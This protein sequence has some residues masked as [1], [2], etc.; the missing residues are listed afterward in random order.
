MMKN[1]ITIKAIPT[2]QR[3]NESLRFPDI[4]VFG[5]PFY[6]EN[7]ALSYHTYRGRE[8]VSREMLRGTAP[9]STLPLDS[10]QRACLVQAISIDILSWFIGQYVFWGVRNT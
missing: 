1:V 5:L 2:V 6:S 3:S 4:K 10:A 9:L 7:A 8:N